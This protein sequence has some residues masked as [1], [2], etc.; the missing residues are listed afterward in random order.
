M[1]INDGFL[2][3]CQY[4]ILNILNRSRMR[5]RDFEILF[6]FLAISLQESLPC[7]APFVNMR[8]L[9][10]SG[11]ESVCENKSFGS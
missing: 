4:E 11:F 9:L 10:I 7:A 3:L 1:P 8:K 2:C 5:W 6:H